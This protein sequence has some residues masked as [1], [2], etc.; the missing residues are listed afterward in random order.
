MDEC[1][2][3]RWH[4]PVPCV[5]VFRG[6]ITSTLLFRNSFAKVKR[7]GISVRSSVWVHVDLI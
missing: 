7:A 1:E 4:Y 2:S 6:V 5:L 3:V